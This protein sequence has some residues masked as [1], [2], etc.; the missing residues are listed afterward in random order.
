MKIYR[1]ETHTQKS[2]HLEVKPLKNCKHRK[3]DFLSAIQRCLARKWLAKE[4]Y[5]KNSQS[6]KIKL[7]K[8]MKSKAA[9]VWKN[10]QP[11]THPDE[12]E[13][14]EYYDC[15]NAQG[16]QNNKDTILHVL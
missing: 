9:E 8:E 7:E 4:A 3:E 11:F 14:S 1:K 5:V 13:A 10:E 12:E 6:W 15:L 16:F 2:V